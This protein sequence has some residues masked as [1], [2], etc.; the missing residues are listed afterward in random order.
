VRCAIVPYERQRVPSVRTKIV[1][2]MLATSAS[3]KRLAS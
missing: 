1:L 3:P 2:N